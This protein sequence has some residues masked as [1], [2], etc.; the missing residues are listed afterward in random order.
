MEKGPS[1]RIA[2]DGVGYYV[3]LEGAGPAVLLLH[4]FAGSAETWRPL[5]AD[6]RHQFA[7]MAVDLLGHGR[8]D[9]P[10]DLA[11]YRMESVCDD[12]ARLLDTLGVD[13]IHLVGYSMGGRIAL[14]F[15][16]LHPCRVNRLVLESASPGLA[17]PTQRALRR[18][19]D[20]AWA[21]LIEE[22]GMTAFVDRWQQQPLFASQSRLDPGTLQRVRQMRLAQ[23]AQGLAATLRQLG[24]GRQPSW[25]H[26]LAELTAPSLFISGELDQKFTRLAVEMAVRMRTTT[27]AIVV[28]GVGHTV[29]LEAPER[30]SSLVA[31]FLLPGGAS[32][33]DNRPAM[34][35]PPSVGQPR[36]E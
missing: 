26:R 12:L 24:S 34:G 6:W 3:H 23:P 30:F 9:C 27:Q 28:P 5:L 29:H 18:E 10:P 31:G 17:D 1:M 19:S 35:D 21:G 4:G 13:R 33:G 16:L 22:A 14:S 8:S 25:W 2:I 15:A 7:V 20:E 36:K 11:R 32:G